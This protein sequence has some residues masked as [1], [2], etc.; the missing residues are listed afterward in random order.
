MPNY[1]YQARDSGGQRVSGQL[2]AASEREAVAEL[3]NRGLV[4]TSLVAGG[5]RARGERAGDRREVDVR[6]LLRNLEKSLNE[7][8][9]THRIPLNHLALFC[10]QFA[11]MIGAGLSILISLR[12]IAAQATSRPLS[13]MLEDIADRLEGG[14]TLSK[15][16]GAHEDK[17]PQLVVHM[18]SAGEVGGILEE[19]FLRMANQF[20][21]ENAVNQKVKS[22]LVYPKI[23]LAMSVGM[24]FFLVL[25]V[26]PNFTA[27]FNQFD[28]MLPL[29]T[30][31]VLKLGDFLS[32]SGLQLVVVAVIGYFAFMR[33]ARTEQGRELVDPFRLRIPIFGDL[34]LKRA[35]ARFSRTL[36]TLLQ[37][38]VP[39]LTAMR[40]T[41]KTMDNAL[42]EKSLKEA[43]TRV[44]GG[45]SLAGPLRENRVFPRM[46]VEMIT[47]GEET[48]A[49]DEMLHKAAEFYE[50]EVNAMVDRLTAMLEPVL[51]VAMAGFVGLILASMF[52]PIYQIVGHIR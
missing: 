22:A 34:V 39:I 25:T 9:G 48:G 40:V 19:V 23:I 30:K 13:Q 43:A 47:V 7:L 16:F 45:R 27:L 12:T 51:I 29:P 18:I 8:L 2:E 14:D 4:V 42:L 52:L 37:S 17:I 28:V 1:A 36:G 49:L 6:E 20:E 15:A 10:R 21:R 11:T 50:G 41:E 3:R 32:A 38:G 24:V 46:L 35:M 5:R 44:R 33:Y 31:M 26:M